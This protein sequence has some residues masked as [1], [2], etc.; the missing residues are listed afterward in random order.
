MPNRIDEFEVNLL[1]S[2]IDKPPPKFTGLTMGH[3]GLAC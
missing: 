3:D 2:L 1:N